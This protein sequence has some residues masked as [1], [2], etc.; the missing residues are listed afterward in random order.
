MASTPHGAPGGENDP[1]VSV[2]GGTQSPAAARTAVYRLRGVPR[3]LRRAARARAVGE[4]TSLQPVLVQALQEY[5]AGTWTPRTDARR[6]TSTARSRGRRFIQICASQND[7]FALDRAGSVHQY[8]FTAQ[9]WERLVASRSPDSPV[10]ADR[11]PR[12]GPRPAFP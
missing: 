1:G 8:N 10:R 7:L 9:A 12:G 2:D 3:S 11:T 4:R 6:S 5:A